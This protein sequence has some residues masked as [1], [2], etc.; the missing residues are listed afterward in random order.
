[1]S[2]PRTVTTQQEFLYP[3]GHCCIRETIGVSSNS[4][5]SRVFPGSSFASL[6]CR[7]TR[8]RSRSASSGS[9]MAEPELRLDCYS[10]A[11]IPLSLMQSPLLGDDGGENAA[12]KI[13]DRPSPIVTISQSN[14]PTA[15]DGDSA[16]T[17]GRQHSH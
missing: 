12:D 4:K 2:A 8:R 14:P 11:S 10:W 6:R 1:M 7:S 16:S 3:S 13:H 17:T 5:F 9:A 15:L